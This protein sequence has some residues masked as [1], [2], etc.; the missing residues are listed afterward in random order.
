ML[1][2]NFHVTSIILRNKLMF[3]IRKLYLNH[4]MRLQS[5]LSSGYD[6]TNGAHGGMQSSPLGVATVLPP[7]QQVLAATEVGVLEEDPGTLLDLAGVDLAAVETFLDRGQV[8]SH[9]QGLT[10][11]VGPLEQP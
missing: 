6:A 10:I 5:S 8:L 7:L 9:L 2:Y 4:T 3:I 11:E 1:F